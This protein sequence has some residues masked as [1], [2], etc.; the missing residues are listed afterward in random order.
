[1]KGNNSID[2]FQNE[3]KASNQ[4]FQD[5]H[6]FDPDYIPETFCHREK[7]LTILSQLFLTLI[8]EPNSISRKILI[9]GP[10][11]SGKTVI[12]KLFVNMLAE[13]GHKRNVDI[14]SIF[15]SCIDHSTREQVLL[16]LTSQLPSWGKKL[17]S[18]IYDLVR[19]P[20]SDANRRSHFLIV[21]DD[22]EYYREDWGELIE[23]I[24]SKLVHKKNITRISYIAI[25]S[26]EDFLERDSIDLKFRRN[27]LRFS[28][29]SKKELFAILK[30]RA[31]IGFHSGV[32][33]DE[34]IEMVA[35]NAYIKDS[36]IQYGLEVLRWAGKFAQEDHRNFIR[37]L[38]IRKAIFSI[39]NDWFE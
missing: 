5:K 35:D 24:T 13:A 11:R 16:E 27:I 1:M 32:F 12:L 33:L 9:T 15:L 4:I 20:R 18:Q 23:L 19:L 8:T 34:H 26:N 31:N 36:S 29:H 10:S 25:I 14:H 21:L 37:L 2:Y 39:Q 7:E 38:D 30:Y 22:I 3:L 28:P 6:V 17:Y